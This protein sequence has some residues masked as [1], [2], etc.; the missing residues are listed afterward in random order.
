MRFVSGLGFALRAI[1]HGAHP[2]HLTRLL[3]VVERVTRG[4]HDE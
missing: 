2:A 1:L 4:L 3:P